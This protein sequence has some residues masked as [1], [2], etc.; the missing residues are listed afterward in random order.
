MAVIPEDVATELGRPT[1]L[2]TQTHNQFAGWIDR[3]E[4]M[5]RRRADRLGVAWDDIDPQ[6]LDDV[7]L[8]VVA[9]HAQNPEAVESYDISVDDG[10]EMRRYRSGAGELVITD[11]WWNWLFPDMTSGAFSTRP[12]G[13]PDVLVWP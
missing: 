7:V 3:T 11:E 9:K 1:P 10:R 6:T 8:L 4:R 2:D 5:I 13:A 12:Y